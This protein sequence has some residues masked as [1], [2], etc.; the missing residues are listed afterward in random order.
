MNQPMLGYM[1]DA[2]HVRISCLI[3]PFIWKLDLNWFKPD[4][5]AYIEHTHMKSK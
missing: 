4:E 1:Q 5:D 2:S 3:T